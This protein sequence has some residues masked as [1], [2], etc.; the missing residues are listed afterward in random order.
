[1]NTKLFI[2]PILS[3]IFCACENEFVATRNKNIADKDLR[4]VKVETV[5]A[6][7]ANA[8][9][10]HRYAGSIAETAATVVSF[11]S[12]GTVK[13]VNVAE[14]KKVNKGAL[15][16]TLDETSAKNALEIASALKSQAEDA[17]ARME[18]LY[19]NKTISEIQWMDV[20]S[21]YKQAVASEKLAQKALEDC[22]LFAPATGII[23]GKSLEVG[24]NVLPG[25]PVFKIVDIAKVKARA[26]VPEKEIGSI[27]IDDK[28]QIQVG[29]LGDK[30]FGGKISNKGISANPLSR[31]Y[32]IEAEIPNTDGE[33]LPG[34]LAEISL[35]RSDSLSG[36][37]LP[38]AAVML[39]EKNRKFV[40]VVSGGRADRR[41]IDVQL[42]VDAAGNDVLV[43]G[44]EPGDTVIVGGMQKVGRGTRV[45]IRAK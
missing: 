13:S 17:R 38:T 16:A 29:A 7:S 11:S 25:V 37:V 12:P 2:L 3:L 28:V 20:E 4:K 40:W 22:K 39:D 32:E 45:E 6:K 33:L 44:I 21:K 1:M 15:V 10:A 9:L 35:E 41:D 36:V 18:K 14:G 24:Q 26:F 19:Q 30:T 34:M 42:S 8:G 31:N 27:R 43:Q 5:I 23:S